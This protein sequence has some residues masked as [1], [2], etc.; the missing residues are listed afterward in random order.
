MKVYYKEFFLDLNR[1]YK[2]LIYAFVLTFILLL[3]DL[4]YAFWQENYLLFSGKTLKEVIGIFILSGLILSISSKKIEFVLI[5]FF[6]IL[7]FIELLHY[8]FFH[9]L[10]IHYEIMFLFTQFSEVKDSLNS[11]LDYVYLPLVITCMQFILT[12]ILVFVIK[13]REYIHIK[14]IEFLIVAILVFV[15]ISAYKRHNIS[16]MMPNNHSISIIN[17]YNSISLFIGKEIPKYI[18]KHKD[19]KHFKQYDIYDNNLTNLPQNIV[20][21]MGESLG[22]KYMHLFYPDTNVEDT[23]YLDKLKQD[24]NFIYMKGY[25]GGVDTLTSVPT[26]FLLKREPENIS[27]LGQNK[28]NLLA[29]AKKHN[30][31]V[32][33]ITTQKLNIMATY[34][35]SADIIKGLKGKDKLLIDALNG[36]DFSKKNFIIIHQR[37]SHSPYEDSTPKEFYKYD[38]KDKD[39]HTFMLNSYY[40]SVLYT[41]YIL[42]Q[43]I[44][45]VKSLDNSVVFVTSDHSE[46][47]GSSDE[48]GRYGHAYLSKEVAKV[49]I[50]IYANHIDNG[51]KQQ[52]KKQKCFNHYTLGKLI[53]NTLGY[54]INNQNDN[55]QYFINGTSIDGSNSFISYTQE[56]CIAL[57]KK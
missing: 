29:L 9:G 10:L 8:S 17:M 53:A 18:T 44:D 30:Y 13:K 39:Y 35:S 19:I 32:S 26:F 37:N 7:S 22:Y 48:N 16:S 4:V 15:P 55:G 36:I 41:D 33:Y 38:F 20:V 14:Y 28:T 25:S 45:K 56:E 27:L 34:T 1:F 54:N 47:L 50:L 46:M 6:I 52:Y 12:Y 23:P 57:N 11:I 24:N 43:I 21:V 42:H 5:S 31:K 51:L 2:H 40:N 49:P 3:P